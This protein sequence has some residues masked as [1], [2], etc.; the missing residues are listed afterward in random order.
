MSPRIPRGS[1]CPD[2]MLIT[3]ERHLR[4]VVSEYV[5]RPQKTMSP[6]DRSSGKTPGQRSLRRSCTHQLIRQSA[7]TLVFNRSASSVEPTMNES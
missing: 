6:A 4:L 1:G 7:S 2:R 3:S 5:E